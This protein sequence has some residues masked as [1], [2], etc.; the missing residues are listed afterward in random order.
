MSRQGVCIETKAHTLLEKIDNTI[1]IPGVGEKEIKIPE[2]H[3]PTRTNTRNDEWDFICPDWQPGDSCRGYYPRPEWWTY[4]GSDWH[5]LMIVG[6][7]NIE[8]QPAQ[9]YPC[10]APQY[11]AD[12]DGF[13]WHLFASD[14]PYLE[15]SDSCS[16]NCNWYC[17]DNGFGNVGNYISDFK[18]SSY[19][20]DSDEGFCNCYCTPKP[21][22]C[23][24]TSQGL[25]E[26]ASHYPNKAHTGPHVATD[27]ADAI[28]IFYTHP[29]SEAWPEGRRVLFGWNYVGGIIGGDS[30]PN[31]S[32]P[33]QVISGVEILTQ[34]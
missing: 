5:F 17:M 34:L 30:E 33:E 10:A 27:R 12:L 31:L 32:Y 11:W 8:G 20:P 9:D 7:I 24:I 26:G 2:P 4:F 22:D 18:S 13:H 19:I 23:V 16:A 29:P 15:F 28:G 21:Y 6:Y 14:W 1:N 25:E 3:T